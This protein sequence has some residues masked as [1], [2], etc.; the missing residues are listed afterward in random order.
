MCALA[1][2]TRPRKSTFVKAAV[3]GEPAASKREMLNEQEF[4]QLLVL[5][6][7]RSER[8]GRQFLLMLLSGWSVFESTQASNARQQVASALLRSTRETDFV[9]WYKDG[10]VMGAIFTELGEPA[11]EA[12]EA[13]SVRIHEAIKN[14]VAAEDVSQV[15]ITFHL[16]PP[17]DGDADGDLTVYP[18]LKNRTE[19]K[20]VVRGV[21][22]LLDVTGSLMALVT[23]SPVFLGIAVAIKLTSKGPIFFRQARI[24]QFSRP[25]TFLKFR[26]M[27]VDSNSEIHKEYVTNYISGKEKATGSEKHIFKITND[28]R[29]TSVG[30]FLRKTSLDE[31]PQFLNVLRGDMSLVG[32]RPPLPYEV[33]KYDTWHRRRIL[34]A[35]PGITGLWQVN[36]RSRTTFDEMVRMDL[37]Y[38][39][40]FSLLLDL[41]ILLQTPKAVVSGSGA[42]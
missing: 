7:K 9:G 10:T 42:Y 23:L 27:Y 4:I 2:Q 25:F 31:L 22:R 37:R 36:G 11:D 17:N 33:E 12:V 3:Q 14:D 20:K 19:N 1:T 34:E 13:V 29:V 15:D 28:P 5:E 8:S 21:K 6:R 38:I 41:K 24:G 18:D 32:P 39:E 40:Q 30:R 16:F 35:R 26:S